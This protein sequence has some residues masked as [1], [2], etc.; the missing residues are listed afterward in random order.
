MDWEIIQRLMNCFPNSFVN[1][2]GEFVAHSKA[3]EYFIL[4]NCESELDVKCKVLEW[5]SRGAYKTEPYS[6]RQRNAEFH[7]FMRDGINQFLGTKFTKKDIEQIYIYLGNCCN[8]EKT[9]G[10]IESGYDLSV[11]DEQ[12]LKEMEKK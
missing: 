1:Q 7:K 12:A 8:H 6:T 3:N 11:L 4:K 10:F 9:I 2:Y 5:F